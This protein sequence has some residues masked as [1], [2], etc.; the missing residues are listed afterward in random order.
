[1]VFL[2]ET[3]ITT[4]MTPSYAWAPRG[5]RAVGSVPSWWQTTTVI[6]ALGSEGVRA[7][8]MFSGATNATVFQTDVDRV[9]VP[10]LRPGDVVVLDN[11]GPH[12][13]SGVARSIQGAGARVLPLPP[14][15]SDFNAIADMWSKVKQSLRRIQARTKGKLC[16][17]LGDALRQVTVEDIPGWFKQARLCTIHA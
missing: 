11:L 16:N 10:E 7:P 4:T 14:Y 17:A 3:G 2:D 1:L 6:A 5:E 9:L 8:L 12:L 15:R 13:T